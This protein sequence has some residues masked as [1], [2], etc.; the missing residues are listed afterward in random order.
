MTIAVGLRLPK[1]EGC[2]LLTDSQVTGSDGRIW[3][4]SARKLLNLPR[5][6]VAVSGNLAIIENMRVA[7]VQSYQDVRQFLAS[8]T[9]NYEFGIICYDK[10]HDKLW[11][12]DHSGSETM[13]S[14]WAAEGSG[15]S[16]AAGILATTNKPTTFE[17]A[18]ELA[19]MAGRAACK[20]HAACGG[21]LRWLRLKT[22]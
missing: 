21:P 1:R 8:S 14:V 6:A 2:V 10:R 4:R 16:Y 17:Q 19:K 9:L 18:L 5:V 11:A 3:T 22:L 13:H 7:G 15:S 12:S 20:L